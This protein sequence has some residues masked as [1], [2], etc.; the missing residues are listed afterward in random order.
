[1]YC[2][3]T[4]WLNNPCYIVELIKTIV[5][6]IIN[7][8]ILL[9]FYPCIF[10]AFF[11]RV[12]RM[13]VSIVDRGVGVNTEAVAVFV[14][15]TDWSSAATI[16]EDHRCVK[17][18]QHKHA[19]RDCGGSQICT[20]G[21]HKSIGNACSG[22]Q[23]R[24]HGRER[25]RC[26]ECGGSTVCAHNHRKGLCQDFGCSPICVHGRHTI[27]CKESGTGLYSVPIAE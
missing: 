20:H 7:L 23:I 3:A 11:F 6:E 16:V 17:H 24:T 13:C 25:S 12:I 19:G 21:R 2:S 18:D 22:S 8:I 10:Q 4:Y 27:Q 26:K 5:K 15:T 1:M 9:I 14:H